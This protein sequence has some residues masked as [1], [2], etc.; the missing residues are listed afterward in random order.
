MRFL[1]ARLVV[2]YEG[3]AG[4]VSRELGGLAPQLDGE[5]SLL[6]KP[7]EENV[8]TALSF[9]RLA[10]GALATLGA[11]A[12]FLACTGVYGVVAF[13][14]GR[15]RREIGVR[16]ALGAGAV[17]V[18]RLLAW[19]SLRPVLLGTAIGAGFAAAA[20][21]FIQAML[22]GISPLD[23]TGYISALFLLGAVAAA[24]AL[25][26]ASAALRVD[27]SVTLRHD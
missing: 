4:A 18:M 6:I 26:P 19:Q 23:P 20:S 10:A 1:E 13:T 25:V 21:G 2:G 24:A 27:P 14:V 17:S 11:L 3:P 5:V 15:R 8:S 16:L 22:Y 9:V 7:I 12:L